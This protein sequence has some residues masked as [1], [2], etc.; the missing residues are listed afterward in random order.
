MQ[1]IAFAGAVS[2]IGLFAQSSLSPPDLASVARAVHPPSGWS[3]ASAGVAS[4]EFLHTG[5]APTPD[6]PPDARVEVSLRRTSGG[7]S[8]ALADFAAEKGPKATFETLRGWPA[9]TWNFAAPPAR[10]GEPAAT[11]SKSLGTYV[12]TGAVVGPR[13]I[14]FST[15]FVSTPARPLAAGAESIVEAIMDGAGSGLPHPSPQDLK[16]ILSGAQAALGRPTSPSAGAAVRNMAAT[17]FLTAAPQPKLID[18]GPGELQIAVSN[19]G[20]D[21]LIAGN[22][23]LYAS[24]D[25]GA[26]FSATVVSGCPHRCLGDPSVGIAASGKFYYSWMPFSSPES[27]SGANT[28]RVAV[29]VS[30][31]DPRT[32]RYRSD[33][34]T[35]PG[36]VCDQ[37]QLAADRYHTGPSG[38]RVYITFRHF[39]DKN[40]KLPP[41]PTITCS[42]DGAQTW[43]PAEQIFDSSADF[44]RLTASPDGSL[45][46]IFVAGKAIKLAK[47]SACDAGLRMQDGFPVNVGTFREPVC[48]IP[49]LDRCNIGND[50]GSP[51]VAVDESDPN[52]VF[53]S[54][55]TSTSAGKNE[56]I[57]VVDSTDGGRTFT[58][59]VRA[60]TSVPARRFMPWIVADGATAYVNWYDRRTSTHKANDLTRYYGTLITVENGALAARESDISRVDEP[61]C[62]NLWPAAPRSD[63]DARSCSVQPELAGRCH[64]TDIACNF[65]R[66]CP[67]GRECE[68]G[69][70]VPKFG[71]YNGLAARNGRRYSVWSS[72]KPLVPPNASAPLDPKDRKR[73]HV[74]FLVEQMH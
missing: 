51:T 46:V 4:A 68:T 39:K 58:R 57:V 61:Q 30:G 44:P 69:E 27:A 72:A 53:A 41:T 62:A 5:V 49:G 52:H 14:A 7:P 21:V 12:R 48:P 10:P 19:D 17:L 54:W 47:Y 40:E 16:G 15:A 22:S 38:D 2:C 31:A 32:L 50:L 28:S 6:T 42:A 36:G 3:L 66:F 18:N 20:T 34:A 59:T 71:D 37:P 74:Y 33:A 55:A 35:C 60:N 25:G 70:G 43:L 11:H 63:T 67:G 8:A 23:G 64:G 45:Y 9:V 26:N 24:V 1:R 29:A 65:N 56:D 73:L 13:L